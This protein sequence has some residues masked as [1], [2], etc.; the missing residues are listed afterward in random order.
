VREF[1]YWLTWALLA[2]GAAYFFVVNISIPLW[3]IENAPVKYVLVTGIVLG[4]VN[5]ALIG[6]VYF[7]PRPAIVRTNVGIYICGA[8]ALSGSPLAIGLSF[9]AQKMGP[10]QGVQFSLAEAGFSGAITT[11]FGLICMYLLSR[12][13][14]RLLEPSNREAACLTP[15]LK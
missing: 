12:E 3:F 11:S 13:Y 6:Y 4:I 14:N 7:Y 9:A 15:Q 2:A 8:V 10:A 1:R 5:I